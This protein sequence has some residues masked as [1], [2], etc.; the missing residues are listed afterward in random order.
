MSRA[1]AGAWVQFAKTGNPN[2]A[3]LPPAGLPHSARISAVGCGSEIAI[4]SNADSPHIDFFQRVLEAMRQ[5]T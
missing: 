5:K 4:R 2:G 1:M 3:S